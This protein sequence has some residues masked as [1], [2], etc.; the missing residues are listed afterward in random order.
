[1]KVGHDVFTFLSVV[2]GM[3]P[4]SSTVYRLSLPSTL[5]QCF[6][7]YKNVIWNIQMRSLGFLGV[8]LQGNTV[9]AY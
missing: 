9:S 4:A 5:W 7:K 3:R 1:M 6:I 2:L 8:R